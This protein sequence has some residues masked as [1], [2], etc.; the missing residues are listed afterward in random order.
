[1]LEKVELNVYIYNE[2]SYF[3]EKCLNVN[4]ILSTIQSNRNAQCVWI[5]VSAV[6]SKNDMMW[7]NNWVFILVYIF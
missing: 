7:F 6:R 1:M 2:N 3:E 5:E 4:D